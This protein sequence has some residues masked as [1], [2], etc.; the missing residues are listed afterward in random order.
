MNTTK[1]TYNGTNDK[2][3]EISSVRFN[4]YKLFRMLVSLRAIKF[5]DLDRTVN[6]IIAE[7]YLDWE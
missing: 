2:K 6:R 1:L 7:V 3:L 5:D 4:V